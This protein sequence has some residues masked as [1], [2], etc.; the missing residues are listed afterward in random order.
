MIAIAETTTIQEFEAYLGEYGV[1]LTR[2]TD[3]TIAYKH[4][5]KDQAIRGERLGDS[6][7]KGA[8]IHELTKSRRPD[9]QREARS[10]CPTET[11]RSREYSPESCVGAIERRMREISQ[12][13]Q[14]L[15]SEGRTQQANRERAEV[16]RT[17]IPQTTARE[18]PLRDPP[19]HKRD[20]NSRPKVRTH[21]FEPDF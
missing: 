18:A 14:Q 3:R 1:T 6:Y 21:D 7:T 17:E 16:T 15:T 19:D 5:N 8:I 10:A 2:N 9:S 13:V 4:P 11:S 20:K 12:G